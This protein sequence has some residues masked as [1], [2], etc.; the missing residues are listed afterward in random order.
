MT[1]MQ[2]TSYIFLVIGGAIGGTFGAIILIIITAVIFV[3]FYTRTKKRHYRRMIPVRSTAQRNV[4]TNNR[5]YCQLNNIPSRSQTW[6]EPPQYIASPAN[7]LNDPPPPTFPPNATSHGRYYVYVPQSMALPPSAQFYPHPVAT[8]QQTPRDPD[9]GEQS[10]GNAESIREAE[11]PQYD[12]I[13][14]NTE[15]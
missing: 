4:A 10:E 9:E 6:Q 8:L 13:F 2:I 5:S 11:P 12:A 7:A 1:Y 14:E 15:L 3:L